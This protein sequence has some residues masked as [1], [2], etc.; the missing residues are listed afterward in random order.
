VPRHDARAQAALTPRARRVSKGTLLPLPHDAAAPWPQQPLQALL[1]QVRLQWRDEVDSTNTR[2]LE[3]ARAG[4]DQP[5]LLVAE[6][7][8]QGRGRSGRAWQSERGQSLMFSFACRL[9]PADWSGL[10]LAVG[11]ALADA[12]EPPVRGTAPRLQLKWPND[13]WLADGPR[14]W[15]K[16]GGIL[17]ETTGPADARTCVVG[18][19]LNL[20]PRADDA[21]LSSGYAWLQEVDPALE[22]PALLLRV[23]PA[24]VAALQR[25]ERHGLEAFAA[26]YAARDLLRG[27]RVA[28]SGAEAH[29]GLADGIDAHGALR[30]V[31]E[32][33]PITVHSGEVSVRPST[34]AAE[35]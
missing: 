21:G 22:A 35:A 1:P 8:T 17:I 11:V 28:T 15:R 27:L 5:V 3:A 10:S 7:Q 29:E 20:R 12:I 26:G 34:Q 18:V 23:A 2:L 25:F 4:L 9:A 14:S 16:A 31:T 6:H 33:G 24:L 30:L 19:G 32:R 13:L